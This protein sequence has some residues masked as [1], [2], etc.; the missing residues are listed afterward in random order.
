MGNT[1][2]AGERIG[3]SLERVSAGRLAILLS[4]TVL[5]FA[6][7][8]LI[9]SYC[10]T[11]LVYTYSDSGLSPSVLDR[12]VDCLYF[13]LVTISSLGYGD[14]RPVGGWRLIAGLEVLVGLA[15]FGL[16]IA[17]A[18]S[19]RTGLFLLRLYQSEMEKKLRRLADESMLASQQFAII[20][21]ALQKG[22]A[23]DKAKAIPKIVDNY[24]STAL[25]L[26][27]LQQEAE[28]NPKFY[29]DIPYD[30]FLWVLFSVLSASRELSELQAIPGWDKHVTEETWTALR[31]SRALLEDAIRGISEKCDD[32]GIGL[33]CSRIL[34][35]SRAQAMEPNLSPAGNP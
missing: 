22:S 13:S 16:I 26:R 31:S 14:I 12:S 9:G 19:L 7:A 33:Q 34:K 30:P 27:E 28:A 35:C 4:V 8:Y 20:A 21:D 6:L 17:K 18:T 29:D 15:F 10:S 5:G 11:A 2:K 25:Q 3:W 32:W 23:D 24:W 1:K